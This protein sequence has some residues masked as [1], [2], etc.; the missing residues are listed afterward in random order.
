MSEA[1]ATSER[2]SERVAHFPPGEA[3]PTA[4]EREAARI[5]K[6]K[7]PAHL[8]KLQGALAVYRALPKEERDRRAA[9][10]KAAKAARL[11]AQEAKRLAKNPPSP[12]PPPD[13]VPPTVRSVR[14]S[15]HAAPVSEVPRPGA[16]VIKGL[17]DLCSAMPNLGD[18]SCFIQ[19]T[20][21]KPLMAFNVPCAGVQKPLW[22]PVDDAEFFGLYGGGEYSI[23]GYAL[24]SDGH[25]PKAATEPVPY[26]VAGHPNIEAA[27]NEE[28]LMRNPTAPAH[29]PNGSPFRRP[30]ALTPQA[31]S[32][33]ADM[34]ARELDHRETMD[35][36]EAERAER[37]RAVAEQRER[38]QQTAQVDAIRII[39]DSKEKEAERLRETYERLSESKGGSMAEMAELIKALKPTEDQAG[40]RHLVENHKQEIRQLVEGHKEEMLRLTDQHRT[41]LQRL[42]ASHESAL[43]RVEDQA[44]LDRERSDTLMRDTE[45]RSSALVREAETRAAQRVIDAQNAAT[46]AYND[47]KA[48]SEERVSDQNNQ[49]QRRFDD[50]K[51]AAARE[52]RQKDSEIALMRSNMEGNTQVILA[53]KDTEIKR[54]QHDLRDARELAEKNKDW[55]GRMGEFEK[56]AEA[57]GFEKGGTDPVEE[58][59]KTTAIKA[60]LGVL[61]RLPELVSAGADAI[62]KIRNPGVPPEVARAQARQDMVRG[63]G[64][65]IPRTMG[66]PPVQF[67]PLPFA[68][69]DGGYTPPAGQEHLPPP[70]LPGRRPQ[71]PQ[72]QT[73]APLEQSATHA[74]VP[75]PLQ[76]LPQQQAQRPAPQAAPPQP[77]A[78]Q[79]QQLPFPSAPHVEPAP[80]PAPVAASVPPPPAAATEELDDITRGMIGQ[81]LP[82][83]VQAFAGRAAP[84]QVAKDIIEL[85][86]I[87]RA[88]MAL[89][90]ATVDQLLLAVN[91]DQT[92]DF[93]ALRTRNGQKFLRACWAAAEQ[94]VQGASA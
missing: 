66:A 22:E 78:P 88:R 25:S 14:S 44:R 4:A 52:M 38:G 40:S 61:Q 77:A 58:D 45:Q 18:G 80:Q 74:I 49:W 81:F 94:Q 83:F 63:S 7:E 72:E 50:Q 86:G 67:A 60:G 57:M 42:Q 75:A 55:V 62:S 41:E 16:M 13:S 32:A 15:L 21:L 82:G 23:R 69:E 11:A 39:A 30:T 59:V 26:R 51:E 3:V 34:H 6:L 56:T 36:R 19:V 8:A 2:A 65:T 12:P 31:A 43:R 79:Q 33:E 89:T 28:D 87:D 1:G 29:T 48:R 70:P 27:L 90:I 9:E 5:A 76:E 54:L 93:A 91:Q 20:R 73:L 46:V 37:R 35:Q 85:N 47:L 10:K 53:G 92:P 24:R 17:L 84:E 64:R 71:I 68:T